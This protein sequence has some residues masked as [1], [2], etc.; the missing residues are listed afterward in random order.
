MSRHSSLHKWVQMPAAKRVPIF[1]LSY[2]CQFRAGNSRI[3]VVWLHAGWLWLNL[4]IAKQLQ[5]KRWNYMLHQ[6]WGDQQSQQGFPTTVVAEYDNCMRRDLTDCMV[7][8]L[9]HKFHQ[10]LNVAIEPNKLEKDEHT[11]TPWL[12]CWKTH[13]SSV[14][15]VM[16][17]VVE[18]VGTHLYPLSSLLIWP[19]ASS[20]NMFNW[21]HTDKWPSNI[22]TWREMVAIYRAETEDS[23][24][25]F[26]MFCWKKYCWSK[27][28]DVHWQMDEE[29]EFRLQNKD[30][31]AAFT[32]DVE[33]V[34]NAHWKF[35]L[36]CFVTTNS[37][38][39]KIA[40]TV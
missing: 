15:R 5:R 1:E 10:F 37:C 19:R 21:V 26:I 20:Y 38:S 3:Q 13:K 31:W 29:V 33:K 40:H 18:D 22:T 34:L 2:G 35:V 32:C 9:L 16:Q 4:L 25:R 28:L 14:I 17:D 30:G 36:N 39:N 6:G 27:T 24:K 11:R 12:F 8:W 7:S 23:V